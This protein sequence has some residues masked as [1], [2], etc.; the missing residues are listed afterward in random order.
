MPPFLIMSH[1]TMMNSRPCK[2]GIQKLNKPQGK[3]K[4]KAEVHPV[5]EDIVNATHCS[6]TCHRA[7]KNTFLE[8]NKAGEWFPFLG[9][10]T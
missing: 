9:D 5:M 2:L 1:Q 7:L 10:V 6:L 4:R 3:K 8:N